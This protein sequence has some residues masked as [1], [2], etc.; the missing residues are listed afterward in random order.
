MTEIGDVLIREG[1]VGD[2]PEIANVHL[3]SWREAYRDILPKNFLD[4]LPLS[5]KR[6]MTWWNQVTADPAAHDLFVAE[7]KSGIVGFS[8]FGS[9]RDPE[10]QRYRELGAIYLFEAFKEKGIGFALLKL[11]MRKALDRGF[12]KS[13]CWVLEN[14]P[15]IRFYERSGAVLRAGHQKQDEIGGK[16]FNEFLYEWND[17][18]GFE[19]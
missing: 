4:Q 11:G 16:V 5:F 9:A 10:M 19:K 12:T 18:E 1:R 3:N 2:A 13:Y 15:T 14:N 8:L 7:A 6:R 17:L